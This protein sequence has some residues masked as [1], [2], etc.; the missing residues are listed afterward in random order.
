MILEVFVIEINKSYTV[1]K[2]GTTYNGEQ[3]IAL[4][5]VENPPD[6]Y[7]EYPMFN[8][9][10]FKKSIKHERKKKLEKIYGET[11]RVG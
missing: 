4:E 1:S 9:R 2:L 10:R 3:T 5:G 8:S 7:N 6:D 11:N